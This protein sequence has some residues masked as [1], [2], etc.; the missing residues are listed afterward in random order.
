MEKTN[1]NWG[2]A[3]F[4][5]VAFMASG[6]AYLNLPTRVPAGWDTIMLPKDLAPEPAHLSRTA[7]ALLLPTIALGMLLLFTWLKSRG[8]ERLTRWL[9]G[10]RVR[11][12]AGVDFSVESFEKTYNL[13][14]TLLVGMI[15][16]VHFMSLALAFEAGRPIGRIFV[17]LVGI[18]F[19]AIGN[20]IPRV[21]P[22]PIMGIRTARTL[23]DRA[24]WTRAHRMLGLMIFC[25]GALV[26]LLALTAFEWG[27]IAAVAGLIVSL[28]VAGIYAHLPRREGVAGALL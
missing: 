10:S 26:V 19:A 15:V 8:G 5:G 13:I 11:E 25:T 12:E 9:F 24:L 22:N 17:L 7:L 6:L 20:F 4:V 28:I 2:G 16:L 3:A 1:R 14:T 18:L 21:R 23:N 27:L